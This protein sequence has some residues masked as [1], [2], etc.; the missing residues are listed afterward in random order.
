MLNSSLT[1]KA[2]HILLHC[3]HVIVILVHGI[4]L[5]T[6]VYPCSTNRISITSTDSL[7]SLITYPKMTSAPA[8]PSIIVQW[9]VMVKTMLII[10]QP[11]IREII[12]SQSKLQENNIHLTGSTVITLGTSTITCAS[13]S[14]SSFPMLCCSP[15]AFAF[16]K[17]I[18]NMCHF[19][20]L[21]EF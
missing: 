8:K 1:P 15:H 21:Q 13:S 6:E 18:Y 16:N 5:K 20:I 14:T 11:V 3:S 19:G 10:L 2:C 9:Y 12:C 17:R 7:F 4:E